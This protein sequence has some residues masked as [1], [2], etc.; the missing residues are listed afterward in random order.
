MSTAA[1]SVT[2]LNSQN[3][4]L[5]KYILFYFRPSENGTGVY[6]Q[7]IYSSERDILQYPSP[8]S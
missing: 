4:V 6:M 8:P 1:I 3:N 2:A 7:K 5:I